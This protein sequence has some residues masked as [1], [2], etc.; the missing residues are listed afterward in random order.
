MA[1]IPSIA[2]LG[3]SGHT[4]RFVVDGIEALGAYA[5]PVTRTGSFVGRDG[6]ALQ[7]RPLDISNP[8]L[9]EAL[10]GAHAV[11]NCAGP[12]F[13]TAEPAA[14][15]A[16]R[17]G[18]P[19]LDVA[20]EQWTTRRLFDRLQEAASDAR[21]VVAP[22]VA[23]YGGLADLLVSALVG[24]SP[25]VDAIEIAVGLDS[26]Q[27]TL[28]TRKTG[29]RNQHARLVVRDGELV[30]VPTALPATQWTFSAPFG[31]QPVQIVPMSEIVLLARHLRARSITSYMN[32][33]PLQD[34]RDASTPPPDAA[35]HRGRS[36]QQFVL[37]ARVSRGG[38]ER[39]AHAFGQDIYAA[40]ATLVVQACLDILASAPGMSG[41]RAIGE[42][43]EPR[44]LL[45]GLAPDIVTHLDDP[46]DG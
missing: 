6:R 36:G 26:W 8:A 44:S 11:I 43:L 1:S 28:G 37:E 45:H 9:D 25:A 31:A 5:I 13:D 21:V 14:L 40:S 4:G 41:V 38:V 30:P 34:L 42:V 46:L 19:Y 7:G 39:R 27:P 12:F 20:A 33:K 15:A 3:A 35:D 16:I 10:R 22:A 18:I 2:V 24:S 23:F 29:D 17:A 32:L